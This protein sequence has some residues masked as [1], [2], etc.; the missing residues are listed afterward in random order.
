MT[1]K[2]AKTEETEAEKIWKEIHAVELDMFSLPGQTVEKYC[3]PAIVEP[4][5]CYVNTSVQA[6]YPALET[7]L[8]KK[9]NVELTTK[10]IVIS[11]KKD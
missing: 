8:G 10:F 3:K 4:S 7:A 6:V 2:K 1:E 11:R 5:K 9:F